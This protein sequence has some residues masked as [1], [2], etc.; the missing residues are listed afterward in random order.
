MANTNDV[1]VK[2]INLLI[3]GVIL[4]DPKGINILSKLQNNIFQIQQTKQAEISV[5]S[6]TG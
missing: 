1:G 3:F 6:S 2:F 4:V 5:E